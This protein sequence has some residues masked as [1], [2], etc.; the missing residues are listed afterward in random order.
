M[1]FRNAVREGLLLRASA[2]F[3]QAVK[4]SQELTDLYAQHTLRLMR[5]F[6]GDG[7]GKDYHILN[8]EDDS[9]A[10]G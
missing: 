5:W 2:T 4:G 3:G 1:K 6:Y 8:L 10:G 7:F 9:N